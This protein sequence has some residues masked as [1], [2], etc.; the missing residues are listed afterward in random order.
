MEV[1]EHGV[2]A[3]SR[4]IGVPD[5]GLRVL[6][7]QE[8]YSP[9]RIQH[10]IAPPV[11]ADRAAAVMG[12]L[13]RT[14]NQG[15][16]S[17]RLAGI[18]LADAAEWRSGI[19]GRVAGREAGVRMLPERAAH[20]RP[21]LRLCVSVHSQDGCAGGMEEGRRTHLLHEPCQAAFGSATRARR[22]PATLSPC[23]DC[24]MVDSGLEPTCTR[25]TAR[26][27]SGAGAHSTG[28]PAR[29]RGPPA[30]R[31]RPRTR[32]RGS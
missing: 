31:W 22:E 17:R 4:E 13:E 24:A 12:G 29:T 16:P 19:C 10:E 23:S 26:P 27:G 30:A 18:V 6:S 21:D 28:W 15:P 9:P 32:A 5:L 7:V 2:R 25:T 11:P 14:E 20:S 8:A 1:Y 3:L